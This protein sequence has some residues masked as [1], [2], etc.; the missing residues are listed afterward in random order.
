MSRQPSNEPHPPGP[1]RVIGYCRISSDA[2]DGNYSIP[3]QEVSVRAYAERQGWEVA[4]VISEVASGR[5]FDERAGLQRVL[6]ACREQEIDAIVVHAADRLSRDPDHAM[7]IL[8]TARM[9][10]VKVVSATQ[11]EL[12]ESGF[13]GDLMW[14]FS[15]HKAQDEWHALKERTQRGR[16]ARVESGKPFVGCRAPYGYILRADKSGYDL[17]PEAAPVVRMMFDRVLAG[18]T[19]RGTADWLTEQG[20]PTPNGG[21]RWSQTTVKDIVNKAIYSGDQVAYANR[22]EKQ[23]DRYLKRKARPE[24]IIVVRDVAPP[25]VSKEEHAEIHRRLAENRAGASRNNRNPE[26]ALL[27]SGHVVCGKCGR[28][29]QVNT[30]RGTTHY[31][32]ITRMKDGGICG[33]MSIRVDWLDGP[34]WERVREL[35]TSGVMVGVGLLAAD[36]EAP[37]RAE[38]EEVE[39]DLAGVGAKQANAASRLVDLADPLAAAPVVGMLN[40]LAA[41]QRRLEARQA[42]LTAQLAEAR[43]GMSGVRGLEEWIARVA[44]NL[45]ALT[46]A[47]RRTVLSLLGVKA[48]VMPRSNGGGCRFRLTVAPLG[49]SE[50]PVLNANTSLRLRPTNRCC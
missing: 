40:A 13:V 35:L 47:E 3:T 43:M 22:W 31:R 39:R 11:P 41:E 42:A 36:P 48:R 5:L 1:V 18:A 44:D 2:Q 45:D 7:V 50:T 21:P 27:R 19:L 23:G 12:S 9:H 10:R 34:V 46:Y 49:L 16:R 26:E 24:E 33:G 29:M 6:A 8:G 4:E 25:I 15:G 32:C 20:I 30:L 17:D 14:L 38:L 37:I 28:W